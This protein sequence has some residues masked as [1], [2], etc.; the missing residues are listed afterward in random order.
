VTWSDALR[1]ATRELRRRPGRAL[2]TVL[3]IALAA[4]LLS[5]LLTIAGTAK[6]RVL[7]QLSH[8][9][10]LAGIT[11]EPNAPNLSQETL[12]DPIPGPPKPLTAAAVGQIK[13]LGNVLSVYPVT[14]VPV[15]VQPPPVPPRGSTLCPPVHAGSSARQCPPPLAPDASPLQAG[16][17]PSF[18]SYVLSADLVHISALPI[19]L[20]AGRLPSPSSSVEVDVG[21][22]Y[23]QQL[24]LARAQAGELVGTRVVLSTTAFTGP[25]EVTRQIRLEVVGVVDQQLGSGDILAWSGVAQGIANFDATVDPSGAATPYVG[26]V[27]IAKQLN[28]VSAVR[29]AIAGI[30]YSTTAPVGLIISV[31]R[32]LHVVELVLSGI[33]L[34]ALAIAALGIA[35]ALLAAIRERR[36]EIGVL[37]ALGAR[38]RDVLHIFL[39]EAGALGL[40]GGVIGTAAGIAMA[41]AIA[42]N[43][44][45]YLH[46]QGLAGVALSVPWLLPLGGVVGSTLVA[47]VAGV[48]PAWRAARLPAR[49]AVDI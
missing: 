11:V 23:L 15:S 13:R 25:L 1:M 39:F 30:G 3:A 18:Y 19:T 46:S 24:G 17:V 34:V 38:D 27:V 28:A 8:G 41:A 20:L 9:G 22:N 47:L 35:N 29:A 32:Y 44:D 4:A 31:G 7:T 6:T 16:Y 45:A 49:A 36:R 2:L 42:G 12:D 43:A 10:S 40:V 48:L 14:A 26:A 37:K 5:A 33:G 21:G